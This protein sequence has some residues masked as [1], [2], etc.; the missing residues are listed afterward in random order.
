MIGDSKILTVSYGTFSC[1]LEGF[2]DPLNTMKAIAEY[3]RDL[4]SD[5]R[6][7]GAEPPTPDAAMLHR[8]AEREV[9]RMVEARVQDKS[10]FLRQHDA[11]APQVAASPA[12][13]PVAPAAPVT[14]VAPAAAAAVA[15]PV[16]AAVTAPAAPAPAAPTPVAEPRATVA[17]PV[18]P[19]AAP[20]AAEESDLPVLHDTIPEGVAAK[21]ARIRQAVAYH[22]VPTLADDEEEDSALVSPVTADFTSDEA[23]DTA[24]DAGFTADFD[25]DLNADFDADFDAG[26]LVPAP[27]EAEAEADYLPEDLAADT[28]S[29]DLPALVL[30]DA[31][32]D[33]DPEEEA[34]VDDVLARLGAMLADTQDHADVAA[35]TASDAD[36]DELA[37]LPALDD[38]FEADTASEPEATSAPMLLL[39][40]ALVADEDE[41]ADAEDLA[42]LSRLDLA[43][44]DDKIDEDTLAVDAPVLQ[45]EAVENEDSAT[46]TA[47]PAMDAAQDAVADLPAEAAELEVDIELVADITAEQSE[48]VTGDTTAADEAEGTADA[49][50]RANARVI[51]IRR[52]DA[53]DADDEDVS[54]ADD[55]TRPFDSA[56]EAAAMSRLMR[57]ADDEMAGAENR[58]RLSAIAHLKAAV[59]ATE[60]ERA[61]TGEALSSPGAKIEP[62][63]D[64]LAH[65][66]VPE[67]AEPPAP[68]RP[69]REVSVR[70]DPTPRPGIRP[71]M[72]T[73]PPLVLV[74][75]QRIDRT[76]PAG[77]PMVAVR[78]GR[79]TGAIGSGASSQLPVAED[80]YAAAIAEFDEDDDSD[81]DNIFSDDEGFAEF[82]ETLGLT[83]L[84]EHL[85]A[86]AA[87]ATIVENRDSFTRPQLM[88]RLAGGPAGITLSREDGLRSFGTLLRTGK[89]EKVR[90]GQYTLASDSPYLA[91]A[92]RLAL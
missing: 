87:F 38:A 74:S 5:D 56:G 62:Y 81:T 6:Y 28:A 22:P 32:T 83:T 76:P 26:T 1:T 68:V 29:D 46:P 60:A 64:D 79:L 50:K 21:L 52:S 40:D 10:I 90:R 4:A 34:G 86:A 51:R 67:D 27:V 48:D 82:V 39:A 88:R 47:E 15:A 33:E 3:F 35:D 44:L 36:T 78:P 9:S 13:A 75:E 17:P 42:D 77:Q 19:A 61:V 63:R 89:I 85:E 58:R 54:P 66:V 55:P 8:I 16:A 84:I 73:A 49:P 2:D 71:E 53:D 25:A 11:P 41:V 59:A 20:P 31:V 91:E 72:M 23:R 65:A 69:R 37:E 24:F 7:F 92:R 43:P 45:A 12:A 57:Q 30:S 18:A 14:P 70:P 80:Q